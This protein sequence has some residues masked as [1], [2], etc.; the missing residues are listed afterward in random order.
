MAATAKNPNVIDAAC[1]AGR[2]DALVSLGER[3]DGC[4]KSLSDYLNTKRN[5]FPRF[6]FISDD[7]L[8]SVL[9]TSDPTSI[10]VHLLKLFDNVKD[11]GFVRANKFI[12]Y[13]GSSEGEGFGLRTQSAVEG[14]VESW[15]TAAEG[16]M[17]AS[18]HAITKEGVFR[19]AGADRLAW[20]AEQL[21]MV[22]VAG[23]QIWWTW[24]T[25]DTF[26]RVR[27]GDK[28]AMKTY[29]EKLT[30]QLLE[31][32][33]K[34]RED[35]PRLL[36]IKVNTLL[37]VDV[38][39]RDIID[40]FVRDS[41][42]DAREFAWESQLR[43]YWDRDADD[44]VIRQC[45]GAFKYGY[46]YMG[47]NGRLVITPLTDRCYMT[48]TQAL[49]FNLGGSPA[50]PAGT[51]KTETVKDL[52]KNL[53]LPCFVINCGEGLDF[54]AMGSIFSG[55][56]QVGAWGCFDEF[57]RINIE[58][59]SVVS[60]Q[61][62][63]I[64]NALNAGKPTVDIGLGAEI[65]INRKVGIF[66]TMNPGYAGRTE[67]PDNL[68]ALFRP[69]TMIVPDL[70]QI[71]EIMLFSEG[72]EGARV[73]AKKMTTLYKLAREQLSKQYHYD[74]GLRAL[75]SVLVM[76]GSLKREFAEMAE[77]LVL[78]RSLRDS[79]LPKFVFE[80]VPLFLGLITDLFPGLDCPRVAYPQLKAAAEA[81][82]ER[83]DMRH[84]DEESF[85]RQVD[86]VIQL[87]EIVLT[88]HTTMIVG[89]TGGGKTV[90][91]QTLQKASGPAFDKS[92]KTFTLNPKAQSVNELY[93]VMDP[94]T[95]DW[96][97]GMLSKL[98][99]ACN[100]PLPAGRENEVRW[101][102]FDGDVDAVWVENMNSVMDD[103]KLLTLPNSERIR[104]QVYCKL[105]IE[106]YDLQYASPATISRCGMIYVDP[107]YLGYKPY[108]VRWV[109]QRAGNK[110]RAN[111]AAYLADLFDKYVPKMV[112]YVLEGDLGHGDGEAE[113]PLAL[114]IPNSGL[115]LVKQL[116]ALLDATLAGDAEADD[117]DVLE[118]HYIWAV[119]WAMGAG[120]VDRDRPRFNAFLQGVAEITTSRG[121]LYDSYFD[122]GSR[123]WVEWASVVPE[124][125]PPVP[126]EFHRIL[127]PTTDSVLYTALLSKLVAVERP[128]L[129]VG[130]SGT[131]KTVT[132][133]NFLARLEAERYNLLNI[134]FSS[135]TT[136]RDVQTNIETNVDK[137]SGK[138]YGPPVGK[139]LMIFVDD[140]NMPRVDKYGTQQ[141]IALLHFLVGR[142]HMYDRGKD[143]DLRTYKDL[144]FT[145]A[146]GP[147][148][149]GRNAVDPRFVALF[150]VF[151]LTAPRPEVLTK[152]YGSIIG[153]FAEG[154]A[155]PVREAAGRVTDAT[156][157][158]FAAIVERLPP[159]PSKFHY[160]FNLRDLGRVYEGLCLATP[161]TVASP[162]AFVRLWRNE[163]LRV[164]SDRLISEADAALV[165]E[166]LAEQVRGSY[167][168]AADRALADPICYGD[169][170]GAVARITDG[171]EDARLYT[172]LGGYAEVRAIADAVL[173][174]YN[175]DHKAMS[176]VLF[177]MALEHLTRIHRIIR[178]PRG[179]ALLV[180]VGGSGKQSLTRL[181]A[182]LAGYALFEVTLVR[183]YGEAD[184]R[185]NLK[186]LYKLLAKGP[187]VFLF[188]DAHVIEEGFLELINNILTTG[189]VPALYEADERDAIINGVRPEVKAA[190]Q[191]DTRENCWSWF[192]NKC[193]NNL[194]LVL[195][196]SPSGDTLRRRCRNFPGLVSN[197]VIDW[198][199]AWPADA[200][201]KVAEYFLRDEALPDSDRPAI[202]QHMVHVHQSVVLAS[203]RFEAELRR[204][205][206]VTP[207]NYLDFIANYRS[208][209]A[210]QRKAIAAQVRRL[211]G[212]LTKLGEA[213]TA[214]DRM[215]VELREQKAV[216]DAKTRDVEA[217]IRNIGDRQASA[218]RQQADAQA[219][220]RELDINAKVIEEE[221]ER[222]NKA[223]EAALPA[224][225]AAASAL[226]N[227]DKD[228]ITE[229]KSFAKPPTFVM[230]V[231]TCVMYLH[232]T[233]REDDSSGWAGAKAM[234][235]D[236]NFLKLLKN[237]DKERLNEKMVKK[238]TQ[239]FT[240]EKDFTVEK[241]RTISTAGAGLLQWVIAIKDYYGVAKDVEPLKKKVK[242]MEKQQAASARELAEITAALTKLNAEISDLDVKYKAAA[243]ELGELR[244]R[245]AV[246]ERRLTAASKLIAGLGS[247]RTRW[248]SDV[249]RLQ[250]QQT[251]LVGDCLLAASF[252]SYLG[253]FTFDYRVALL[254]E[255]W[256][257][258]VAG[259]GV[260]ATVPFVL[261]DL[262]TTE[263][264]VQKW[265]AEGLPADQHSVMNG[266][267]TTRASRFPLCIDP[268]QQ[269][270]AWIKNREKEL[271]TATFLDGDFM[272]PLKLAIQYGKPFL[273][274][275]VDET[276]DPMVDPILEQNTYMDG[277]QRNIGTLRIH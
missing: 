28:Y 218:D 101:I 214:V 93:G 171:R 224:L 72:F 216:V 124:Y 235:S 23:S 119:T 247:E 209:L 4:Q 117:F 19:Y 62:R 167:R 236:T 54:T 163:V 14:A 31:L 52:A 249:A 109:K 60:A 136:S 267:L 34:V 126:F 164:F 151:N 140:L 152:I 121:S 158:F 102:V 79:N 174:A 42:L 166:L 274:E 207:K 92:V 130:E 147:P 196:M 251:R 106:V 100:E 89:P 245:A 137:R 25:E 246:M 2:A 20:V 149:G 201:F 97:D 129:F 30:R 173:E 38:H 205:N 148:G 162:D 70:L 220:K 221:S 113:E 177:E 82:L 222:S 172:D 85:Q 8:L 186:D 276:I 7:E 208:Q 266:M 203:R 15:M 37:I 33:A 65:R 10:K 189:M 185:S 71:C 195:A 35:I 26:R 24:E 176:L 96:T 63:A 242:D 81:E 260:A 47:L 111:E 193:R 211:E 11:F 197:T 212:G 179:N 232:P 18:L 53:A 87:Y 219:K 273:F 46:E 200:L 29:A 238:V 210:G 259:R 61:I 83:L 150:N 115:G 215:S 91:L 233:G 90:V 22:A 256:V 226:D 32:V 125:A 227:L 143:L 77:D 231:C 76:A 241:M 165:G 175:E 64:Q 217:L 253:P 73:L 44:I 243:G 50:G 248:S 262:M 265:V 183:N 9:G 244:E 252:L 103:N 156:L 84:D 264:T 94:A 98:F 135:R 123:K 6:F 16:E 188:T 263:A 122:A 275:N 169:F 58:V 27:K 159:T 181:A 139:R 277:S 57:N 272:Q 146:M 223:L 3:L 204:H 112:A 153:R 144:L 184:F 12:N 258:D 41:I 225:E 66:I 261:E 168:D 254:Q 48:L 67:L 131:A 190:G 206:Y 257:K 198:F 213:Q 43:F 55:L 5:A 36:R 199:F 134:N 114:V 59:L 74:F 51:G 132:I 105:L 13:L 270:V 80:D 45:T 133:Q 138:V 194:H 155:E 240:R 271:R 120:V 68:K 160:I 104:L 269:A 21:G 154:L 255:D 142:G 39:A 99:R 118:G 108:Y 170:R 40:T 17:R 268:Q 145:G 128:V 202:T 56:S 229:I 187:A 110:G 107:K 228:A 180:G 75:K 86:K 127:V 192:V 116:C 141:P 1:E 234:M 78:M 95:R 49:T 178:M 230:M 69:V 88:R 157:K 239:M 161:D 250:A 237:Y 191:F 182:F